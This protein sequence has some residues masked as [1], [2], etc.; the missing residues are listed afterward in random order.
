[1]AEGYVE[2]LAEELMEG[3]VKDHEQLWMKDLVKNCIGILSDIS[4]VEIEITSQEPE[5]DFL[6]DDVADIVVDLLSHNDPEASK[7]AQAIEK[8]VQI[9]DESEIISMVQA[10]ENEQ[11]QESGDN[12]E[13]SPPPVIAKEVYN[14]IQ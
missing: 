6:D 3:H 2:G 4:E 5:S 9:V 14:A 8:Y 13:S 10:E 7:V 11:E 1:L 12:E